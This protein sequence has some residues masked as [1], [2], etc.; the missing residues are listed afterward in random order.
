MTE[1][2]QTDVQMRD[3]T[4]EE[5]ENIRGGDAWGAAVVVS[6]F[7]AGALA[8]PALIGVAIFCGI[9]VMFEP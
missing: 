3:L 6:A 9:V 2:K 4:V 8:M 7:A 1:T 5:L